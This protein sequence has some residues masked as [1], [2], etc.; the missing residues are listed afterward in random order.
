MD[1]LDDRDERFIA[2][3]AKLNATFGQSIVNVAWR[4][5]PRRAALKLA[6][7]LCDAAEPVGKVAGSICNVV[8]DAGDLFRWLIR[9]TE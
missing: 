8:R 1:E 4:V 9:G 3:F 6:I 2:W 7:F 5:L